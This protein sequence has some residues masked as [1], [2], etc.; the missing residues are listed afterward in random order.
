MVSATDGFKTEKN[1]QT[2]F[3]SCRQHVKTALFKATY[4]GSTSINQMP[5]GHDICLGQ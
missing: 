3:Q 5:V 1:N 4:T 2:M